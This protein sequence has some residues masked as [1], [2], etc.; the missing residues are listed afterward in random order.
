[1]IGGFYD[2]GRHAIFVI[3][4]AKLPTIV[5]ARKPRPRVPTKGARTSPA[6]TDRIV[7]AHKGTRQQRRE[8]SEQDCAEAAAWLARQ[9]VPPHES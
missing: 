7:V 4:P 9:I 2:R 6:L 1:M 8:P 5:T 3:M